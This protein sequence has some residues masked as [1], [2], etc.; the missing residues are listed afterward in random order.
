MT[1]ETALRLA[2]YLGISPELWLRLQAEY[3]LRM[4]QH[5]VGRVIDKR[6]YGQGGQATLREVKRT[7]PPLTPSG[8]F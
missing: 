7:R 5:T 8:P 6:V 3:D 4:A 2:K 1:A